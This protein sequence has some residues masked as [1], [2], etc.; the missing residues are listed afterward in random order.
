MQENEMI[1]FTCTVVYSRQSLDTSQVKFTPAR[2]RRA[3]QIAFGFISQ[4]ELNSFSLY[5]FLFS[6]LS[7]IC[8]ISE[9]IEN[10]IFWKMPYEYLNKVHCLMHD[11]KII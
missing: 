1:S 6:Q 11:A 10:N 5:S 3:S 9:N 2:F 7:R 8:L 4:E